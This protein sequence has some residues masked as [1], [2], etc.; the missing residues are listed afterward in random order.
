MEKESWNA[1]EHGLLGNKGTG[2]SGNGGYD[3]LEFGVWEFE[4]CSGV[5][6]V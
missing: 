1:T 5:L 3:I 2:E 6:E 4:R